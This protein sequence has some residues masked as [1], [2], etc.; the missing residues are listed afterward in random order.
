MDIFAALDA[1]RE[2]GEVAAQEEQLKSGK[3]FILYSKY[4]PSTVS[5]LNPSRC[6]LYVV[7][8]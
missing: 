6:Q 7:L 3:L 5:R 4:S 8:I 1:V 2:T